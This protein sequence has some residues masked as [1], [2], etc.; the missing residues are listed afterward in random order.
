M[1]P[2]RRPSIRVAAIHSVEKDLRAERHDYVVVEEPLAIRLAIDGVDGDAISLAITMRTPGHDEEL[3]AGLVFTEGLVKNRGE[4]LRVEP[5]PQAN[6]VVLHLSRT[7][8]FDPARLQRNLYVSSSCG[9]CGKASIEALHAAGC[10]RLSNDIVVSSAVIHN[11]PHI[12]REAQPAFEHTGALHAATLFETDG[13]LLAVREDVGRHNALDKLIGAEF[14]AGRSMENR[15]V[16][17]SGRVGF[18]L[19]Q[20]CVIARVPVLAAVGA[21]S[22]LAIETARRFNVT[23]LGFVR[24]GRFNIYTGAERIV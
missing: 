2:N 22:S 8:D 24:D 4:I 17:L 20:K 16:M 1:Q 10:A 18:E 11:L 19:V 23:L 5:Q 9:V 12:A 14:L 3:G 13:R 21:P 7:A 15:V 6:E